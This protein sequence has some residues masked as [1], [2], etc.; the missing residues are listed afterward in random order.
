MHTLLK[1]LAVA[2]VV[3]IWAGET[4]ISGNLVY[5]GITEWSVES[6]GIGFVAGGIL[7]A[8]TLVCVMIVA[9]IMEA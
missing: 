9:S 3:C 5:T 2:I 4:M 1:Y 6:V 8:L 7:V